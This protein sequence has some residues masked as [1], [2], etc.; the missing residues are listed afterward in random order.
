MRVRYCCTVGVPLSHPGAHEI[1]GPLATVVLGKA[2]HAIAHY[3]CVA[4]TENIYLNPG[5]HFFKAYS[6]YPLRA[7][8]FFLEIE[9]TS[10][11]HKPPELP[12]TDQGTF[13]A[14]NAQEVTTTSGSELNPKRGRQK[15]CCMYTF[16]EAVQYSQGIAVITAT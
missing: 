5:T 8:S 4:G 6:M 9:K 3:P 12:G 16:E 2:V 13:A 14:H 10:I 7:Y 15:C 1:S 11:Q